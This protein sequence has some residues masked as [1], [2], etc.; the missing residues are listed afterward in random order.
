[1]V[2]SSPRGEAVLR[3]KKSA[4]R[5]TCQ[6]Y[7][8]EHTEGGTFR[9]PRRQRPGCAPDSLRSLRPRSDEYEIFVIRMSGSILSAH[10]SPECR[11]FV[12][13]LLE[14]IDRK[15]QLTHT[16]VETGGVLEAYSAS[17]L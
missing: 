1:M 6:I 4:P 15:V 8:P 12:R 17:D 16:P 9:K 7:Q 5:E 3:L 10:R 2:R 14:Q 13:E 11:V